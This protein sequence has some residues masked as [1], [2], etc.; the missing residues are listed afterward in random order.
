MIREIEPHHIARIP[1]V[2]R[3]VVVLAFA[4]NH[5][6]GMQR[7]FNVVDRHTRETVCIR[8][9]ECQATYT[10]KKLNDDYDTKALWAKLHTRT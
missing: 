3:Y 4:T 5:P 2:K 8:F 1:G 7:L 6:Y 10:A 9:R